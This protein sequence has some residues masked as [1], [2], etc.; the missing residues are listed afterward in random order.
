MWI[1]CALI[2]ALAFAGCGGSS[3]KAD[4]KTDLAN[5]KAATLTASDLPGYTATPYQPSGDI[6]ASLKKNFA[7][8][9]HEPATILDD[10]PGAQTAHSPDLKKQDATVSAE[11][12]IDP[13]RSDIDKGWNQLSKSGMEPCLGQLFVAAFKLGASGATVGNP[14]VT[15]FSVGVGSRSVGYAIKIPATAQG[16]SVVAYLDAVFVARDRAGINLF[17]SNV[18]Q[19]F[20]RATEKS[21][22]RTMYDR[23]GSKAS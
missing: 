9:I 16:V 12:E 11:V 10:T 21:L 7:N 2:A 22:V 14:T 15:R 19:P 13:K 4:P 1:G 5:A 8:C 18:G 17:T 20:D 23:V 3:A 6:P